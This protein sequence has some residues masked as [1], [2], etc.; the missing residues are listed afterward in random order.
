MAKKKTSTTTRKTASKAKAGPSTSIDTKNSARLHFIIM[1]GTESYLLSQHLIKLREHFQSVKG[2]VDVIHFDGTTATVADV[3]DEVRSYSLM[4][5]Y[6]IVVVNN[7]DEFVKIDNHR[8]ILEHYTESPAEH[9]TLVLRASIW[10]AG[11][12]D[13][14]VTKIGQIVICEPPSVAKAVAFTQQRCSKRYDCTIDTAAANLMVERIGTK[15]DRIDT[16]LSRLSLMIEDGKPIDI[17]L[18]RDQINLS[19]EEEAWELQSVLLYGNPVK[20]MEKVSE[21][22]NVSKKS[23]VQI[24]YFIID[25]IHKIRMVSEMHSR[26][27][28]YNAIKSKIWIRYDMYN[29][30]KSVISKI[31]PTR[32]STLMQD[33]VTSDA[34]GKSGY[35]KQ[36]RTIEMLALR[37]VHELNPTNR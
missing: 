24:N 4:Q 23:P 2:E 33:A 34:R 18:V 12:L 30:I 31:S 16:E 15:L 17:A 1:H 5:L 20:A 29:Q 37:F 28:D 25:L 36:E 9:T 32:L 7:A 27:M 35:G 6:K 26:G 14:M 22:I 11:N 21:L 8:K 10:R 3:L 13:K 19:R